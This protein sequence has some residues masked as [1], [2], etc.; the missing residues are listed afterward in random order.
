MAE[1]SFQQPPTPNQ[2][3]GPKPQ[4]P[5]AP[6]VYTMPTQYMTG[7]KPAGGGKAEKGKSTSGKPPAGKGGGSKKIILIIIFVVLGLAILGGGGYYV[8]TVVLAPSQP[9]AITNQPVIANLNTAPANDNSNDNS[10]INENDN[11]GLP[12]NENTNENA[13]TNS[14]GNE[15]INTNSTPTNTST[16]VSIN[17]TTD[18]DNDGLTDVEEQIYG[19]KINQPDTDEDGYLDGDEVRNGF[20]PTGAGK[21]LKS[22]K[23]KMFENNEFGYSVYYPIAWIAEALNVE[24]AREVLFT[25]DTGEFMEVIVQDNPS[26]QTV[27]AWYKSQFPEYTLETLETFKVNDDTAVKSADGFTVYFANDNYIYAVTYKYGT[28]KTVNFLTTFEMMYKSF[29]HKIVDTVKGQKSNSNT[30]ENSN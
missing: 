9:E 19:T 23:V 13:N 25:S 15:N 7:Q 10:N 18:T 20:N 3:M 21:I 11:S 27:E 17:S 30:N 8:L 16:P 6:E 24:D 1:P 2:P 26:G 14:G 5:T 4:E 12:T 22:D 29:L 28:K